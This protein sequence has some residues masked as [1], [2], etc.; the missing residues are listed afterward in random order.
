MLPWALLSTGVDGQGDN[1]GGDMHGA[2]RI[3][4]LAVG[5]GIA[6]GAVDAEQGNDIAGT[7]RF[8]LL[9]LV[10]MHPHQTPDLDLLAGPGIDD[11]IALLDRA[12]I[13]PDIGQLAVAAVFQ[14]EGQG[15]QGI[16]RDCW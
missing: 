9:H 10:G 5:E 8:D 6:G 11:G 3:V 12:L 16:C 13:G 7:G 4:E 14:L 1:R 15:H 2:H